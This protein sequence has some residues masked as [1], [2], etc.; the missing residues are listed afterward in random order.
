MSESRDRDGE[1]PVRFVGCCGAYCK[2]CKPFIEGLCKGCKIGYD[3]GERDINRA[4]CIM[5]VC[6]FR[7]RKLETCADCPDYLTCKVIS[8]FHRKKGYKYKKYQQSIEFIRKHGYAKFI[9]IA[10]T[11]KGPYGN[12]QK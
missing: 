8:A 5:K 11:W 3:D 7:E 6:C 10:N 2:T 9:E 12:F 4:K 1:N